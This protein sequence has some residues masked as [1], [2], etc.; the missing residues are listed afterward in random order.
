MKGKKLYSLYFNSSI[1][2][3]E[4]IDVKGVKNVKLLAVS[5]ANQELRVYNGKTLVQLIN[6]K[7]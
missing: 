7:V 1:K 4:V 6:A 3:M 5:L 2:A